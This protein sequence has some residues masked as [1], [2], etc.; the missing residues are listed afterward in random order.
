M[1]DYEDEIRNRISG[2]IFK[3]AFPF[4]LPLYFLCSF[5]DWAVAPDLAPH[6]FIMR[7]WIV[8]LLV[9]C[10]VVLKLSKGSWY[11]ISVWFFALILS[12]ELCYMAYRSG[13]LLSSVYI[14]SISLIA[15]LF[16]FFFSMKFVY[17]LITLLA[18]YL[19]VMIVFVLV[20]HSSVVFTTPIVMMSIGM[21]I[22]YVVVAK[23]MDVFHYA[24]FKN[25]TNLLF[26]ATTDVLSG[27]KLRRFFFNRFIQELSLR[28][29]RDKDF[30]LSVALIDV[31]EF[32]KVNDAYGHEAGDQLIKFI[33]DTIK[34]NIRVYDTP[35]RFGGEEFI[36]LFP[37]T[38]I[39]D[40]GLVCER[41]RDTIHKTPFR[42]KHHDISFTV[43]AGISGVET[44]VPA[45][46]ETLQKSKNYKFL[47]IQQMLEMIK[48]AD[49]SL[50]QAK[51]KG[52]NQVVT[53]QSGLSMEIDEQVLDSLKGYLIYFEEDVFSFP[54][55]VSGMASYPNQEFN[56]YS[57]EY[58]FRRAVESMYRSY[59]N[60]D[61]REVIAFIHIKGSDER[62]I[63]RELSPI[64]RLSD[65]LC[66][67]GSG[68]YG[69][70]FFGSFPYDL[71]KIFARVTQHFSKKEIH[72]TE[73][74]IQVAAAS[75]SYETYQSYFKKNKVLT[76][77]E[78]TQ[79]ITELFSVLKRH[80]FSRDEKIYY[81]QIPN[82][83]KLVA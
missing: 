69:L 76:Y 4:L 70:I 49:R 64:F 65:S 32:K 42:L 48:Q 41:I 81:H 31:D 61:W 3:I 78:F 38:K 16:L 33:G 44:K 28:F 29:R 77:L 47:L 73:V 43:S 6:F 35:C 59:R 54:S 82:L 23:T 13:N 5:I 1:Y 56:F 74:D 12:L 34:S 11:A 7:L 36:I 62:F 52:R 80:R 20:G 17:N 40:A 22:I 30:N 15:A 68:R 75:L 25:K 8:P 2:N 55:E 10:Y 24:S 71:D 14:Y 67:F 53:S 45:E 51:A 58:F 26:L 46:F 60:P 72:K 63:R 27:L 57:E 19:P 18:F 37:D 9:F 50:Y 83:K 66:Q 39:S 79:S 21:F